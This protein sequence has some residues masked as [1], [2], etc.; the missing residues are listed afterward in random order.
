[1][2]G[3]TVRVAKAL[4]DSGKAKVRDERPRAELTVLELDSRQ[5]VPLAIPMRP[6]RGS[7]S[8]TAEARVVLARSRANA[9]RDGSRKTRP[10]NCPVKGRQTLQSRHAHRVCTCVDQRPGRHGATRRSRRARR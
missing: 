7:F 2:S 10:V 9:G 1:M 6:V 3:D 4:V 8:G 5:L